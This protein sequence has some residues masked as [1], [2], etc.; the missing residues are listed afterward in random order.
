MVL[1][2]Y[3]EVVNFVSLAQLVTKLRL[4]LLSYPFIVGEG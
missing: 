2:S 1:I 4:Y 3:V